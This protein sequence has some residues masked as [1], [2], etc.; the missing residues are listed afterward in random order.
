MKNSIKLG[1]TALLLLILAASSIGAVSAAN[2]S[3]YVNVTGSDTSGNGTQGNPYATIQTGVKNTP[4]GGT[5]YITPGIYN[6]TLNNNVKIPRNMTVTG[7]NSVTTI[8]DGANVNDIFVIPPKVTAII[9]NL[10]L[11]NFDQDTGGAI[12]NDGNLTL[13]NV[14]LIGD[15]ANPKSL[16]KDKT[17]A[18]GLPVILKTT[19]V[20]YSGFTNDTGGKPAGW[21]DQELNLFSHNRSTFSFLVGGDERNDIGAFAAMINKANTE[22]ALFMMNIGDLRDTPDYLYAFKKIYLPPSN[23]TH[24]NLPILF[25]VGNHENTDKNDT[26]GQQIYQNLFGNKTY[27]SWTEQNSYFIVIDN[28]IHSIDATQMAWLQ[29]ELAKSQQYQYRF[30]FM[31]VPIYAPP[32]YDASEGMDIT[33]PGGADAL[34]ALLDAN[35]ITMAF[36]GHVHNYFSGVWGN[37]TP[38]IVTAGAGAPPDTLTKPANYHYMRITVTPKGVLYKIVKYTPPIAAPVV[39]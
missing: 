3:V 21:N 17:N 29:N 38:Y 12:W 24:F 4:L 37:N 14:N 26:L 25:T 7:M 2:N 36:A 30:I 28:D 5:L 1:I 34:T 31:H 11:R 23:Y 22:N 35:H 16:T 9:Q 19:N 32:G 33:G 27:F 6:G 8:I 39:S 10:T 15:T 13:I 20:T 18:L